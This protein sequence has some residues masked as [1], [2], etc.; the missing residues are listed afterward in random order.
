MIRILVPFDFSRQSVEA[1][2]FATT[3]GGRDYLRICLVHAIG[4]PSMINSS[5]ALELERKYMEIHRER[6]LRNMSKVIARVAKGFK[7]ETVVDFGGPL[8]VIGTAVKKTKADIIVMGTQGASGLREL[9]V[10]S[11]TQK[12]VRNSLVP[13]IAVRK[14]VKGF[15]NIVL[16]VTLEGYDRKDLVDFVKMFQKIFNTKV[17]LLFVNTP[18]A[19][20]RDIDVRPEIE[21]FSRKYN[22]NNAV[23]HVV[24]DI[25]EAGGIVKFAKDLEQP[26]VVM[27]TH[28]RAGLDHLTKGSVAEDVLNHLS[29]PL[30]TFRIKSK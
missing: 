3:L 16:P 15:R 29:C 1:L 20:H 26:L 30:A 22:L 12:V 28:G 2:K 23:V 13:V 14:A 4:L 19:F 21:A 5:V 27:S 9:T 17:H 24:N 11:N 8:R 25:T 18:A 7:V 10:G 6:A